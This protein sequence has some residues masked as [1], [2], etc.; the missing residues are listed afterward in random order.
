M[1]PQILIASSDVEKL[2]QRARKLKRE[3][4]ISHHE[5]LDKIAMA[6]GFD[7]WHHVSDSAK[8][9]E[10]TE[11]SYYFGVIIA[12]DIKDADGFHDPS[13]QFVEAPHAYTLCANDIYTL[14][15]EQEEEGGEIDTNDPSYREDF[16]EWASDM[17]MNYVFYRFTGPLIPNSAEDVVKYVR[18]CCFWPPEFIW[19]RGTFLESPSDVALDQDGEVAGVRFM[20]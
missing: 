3:S 11:Q 14:V 10:P 7:H 17:L 2:K 6:A 8:A 20:L 12:M 9:F 15:R 16:E 5:A 18:D 19:H 13:G 4:G 1:R